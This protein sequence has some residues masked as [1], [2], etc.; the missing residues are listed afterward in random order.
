MSSKTAAESV[1]SLEELKEW[2]AQQTGKVVLTNGCF[3]I[4]HVGHL[5][6]LEYARSLGDSLVVAINSDSSVKELKG[7]KRPYVSEQERAELISGLACVDAT[8]IFS[9]KRLNKVISVLKPDLYAKG[10]DYTLETMDQGERAELEACKAE[11]HFFHVVEGKSTT[12]VVE[13][14][15]QVNS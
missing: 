6:C 1:L 11:I 14:I 8:V 10:G 5:R 3:D 7:D 4:V 2:R 12:N 13:N 9:E 15:L